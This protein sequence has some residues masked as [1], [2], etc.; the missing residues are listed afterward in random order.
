MPQIWVTR[1]LGSAI[2]MEVPGFSMEVPGFS[3]EVPG[4]SPGRAARVETRALRTIPG[5]R[6]SPHASAA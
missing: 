3:T 1:F 5:G 2:S 4:F 6:P